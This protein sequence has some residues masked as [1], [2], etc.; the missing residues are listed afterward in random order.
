MPL[1]VAAQ[2]LMITRYVS[3]GP[4][5]GLGVVG[6]LW[7]SAAMDIGSNLL[8]APLCALLWAQGGDAPAQSPFDFTFFLPMIMIGVLFYFMLIRPERKKSS[9][10]AEMLKTLKKNDYVVTIGGIFGTV[11]NVQEGSD[12]VTLRI[13]EN[14]NA[15]I[16]VRRSA[17]S[18]IVKDEEAAS[19]EATA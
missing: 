18:A 17:I 19:K 14:S 7:G 3:A 2:G 13:D 16:R 10:M 8:L 11:V 15:K 1:L 5:R 12:V 9:E 4:V 6:K